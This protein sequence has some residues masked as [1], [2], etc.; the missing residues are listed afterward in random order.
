MRSLVLGGSFNPVHLGHLILIDE[1]LDELGAERA[2]LVPA[3]KPPHKDK[4]SGASDE[5]RLSMLDL[6][7]GKDSRVEVLT[8]EIERGGTSYTV[9][10]LD[11]LGRERAGIGKPFLLIGD[12]LAP[13][14]GAWKDPDRIAAMADIVIAR[15]MPEP[16]EGFPWPHRGL[17]NLLVPISS[18]LVRLRAGEDRSFKHL[19]PEGVF[20]YI[21]SRGLYGKR[22]GP[23]T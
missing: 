6:A 1:A 19:V 4:P 15:R 5:D 20:E 18:S 11:W 22:T 13:G 23:G 17:N 7:V 9:D 2:F 16:Q 21:R 3:A 10:T 8:C 12:D 14:F